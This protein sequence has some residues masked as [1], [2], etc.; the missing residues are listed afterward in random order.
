MEKYPAHEQRS[1][2][3]VFVLYAVVTMYGRLTAFADLKPRLANQREFEIAW[4]AILISR[5]P[6]VAWNYGGF[7]AHRMWHRF[8][9]DSVSIVLSLQQVF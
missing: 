2:P 5:R 6:L 4:A 8:M 9:S 3:K 7:A 1:E